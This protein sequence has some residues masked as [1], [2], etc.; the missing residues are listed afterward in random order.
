M[1]NKTDS[2]EAAKKHLYTHG[3]CIIERAIG[4]SEV[5]ALHDRLTEQAEAEA[6]LDRKRI[7]P[8]RKRLI[9]FL[10]NKGQV[11]RDLLFHPIMRELVGHILGDVY[12]LSQISGGCHHQQTPVWDR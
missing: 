5:E 2:L 10:I 3:Y 9:S 1:I 6:Q 11:F 7:L 4:I 8:D 12:L